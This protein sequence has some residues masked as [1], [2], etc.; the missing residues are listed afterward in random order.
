M[1][2]WPAGASCS[3]LMAVPGL[4]GNSAP[5]DFHWCLTQIDLPSE[6]IWANPPD[7]LQ[8]QKDL[9]RRRIAL[10]RESERLMAEQKTLAKRI[11][12][13]QK[14]SEIALSRPEV[15]ELRALL[16]DTELDEALRRYNQAIEPVLT[17]YLGKQ[18]DFLDRELNR[19]IHHRVPPRVLESSAPR[20]DPFIKVYWPEWQVLRKA[21]TAHSLRI[22]E[23]AGSARKNCP[24]PVTELAILMLEYRVLSYLRAAA[25]VHDLIYVGP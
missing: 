20:L 13:E 3:L 16:H 8:W 22:E 5:F 11:K 19:Q 17:E 6:A 10:R 12:S 4:A 18:H 14:D 9:W 1:H 2:R 7:R 24:G 23:K 21:L 15:A 25:F